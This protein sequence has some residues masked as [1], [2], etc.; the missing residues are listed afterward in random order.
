MARPAK[1]EE[2]V[3]LERAMT[4]F[5]ELGFSS[6]SMR[7]LER[8]LDVAAP[9]IYRHF[10]NKDQLFEQ[11]LTHYLDRVITKRIT[12]LLP[13]DGDPIQALRAFFDT[14]IDPGPNDRTLVGC[15]VANSAVETNALPDSCQPLIAKGAALVHDAFT[16]QIRR[17][18]DLDHLPIHAKPESLASRMQL[19]F[20]GLM[21]LARSGLDAAQLR[22]KVDHVF[23][24]LRR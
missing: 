17:A 23:D 11:C 13:P 20:F 1:F 3:L 5:W 10:G 12:N 21:V 14:S 18:I 24:D 19:D 2:S 8:S 4:T 15:L 6:T 7:D 9:S 22:T 16:T